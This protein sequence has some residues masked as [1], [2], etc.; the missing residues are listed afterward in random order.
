MATGSGKSLRVLVVGE[1]GDGKSTLINHFLDPERETRKPAAGR[2]PRGVTKEITEYICCPL[3]GADG[4]MTELTM[5]DS[6]GIGDQ[7]VTAPKL[8]AMIENKLG[9]ENAEEKP[10]DGV[11]VT[12]LVTDARVKLGA[13]VVQVLVDKGTTDGHSHQHQRNQ[14]LLPHRTSSYSGF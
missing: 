9:Q 5:L 1:C 3:K 14:P 11:L 10:L 8:L 13:Q 4:K 12:A 7:D 2:N 6:P